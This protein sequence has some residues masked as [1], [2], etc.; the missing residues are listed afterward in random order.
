[1]PIEYEI[2]SD[3]ATPFQRHMAYLVT[4][5]FIGALVLVFLPLPI[6]QEDRDLLSML[7]GMLVSKWQTIIDFF[8]T[9]QRS[10]KDGE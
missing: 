5:I 6:G 2:E 9:R 4:A 10:V 3:K 8:F 1:M 7:I